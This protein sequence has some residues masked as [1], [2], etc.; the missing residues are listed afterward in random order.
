MSKP[1][2]KLRPAN[3]TAFKSQ[4]RNSNRAEVTLKREVDAGVRYFWSKRGGVPYL[5]ARGGVA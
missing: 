4:R 2:N 3:T 5:N 1:T